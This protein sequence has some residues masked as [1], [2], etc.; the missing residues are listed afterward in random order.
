HVQRSVGAE[1]KA[2]FRLI[3]LERRHAQV[4]QDA[5]DPAQ[6]IPGQDGL[7]V[8]KIAVDQDDRVAVGRQGGA[9]GSQSARVPID[10]QQPPARQQEGQEGPGVSAPAHRAVHQHLPRRRLQDL[11][12]LVHHYR[13]VTHRSHLG[14]YS[15]KPSRF[16]AISPK[17][18]PAWATYPAQRSAAQISTRVDTPITTASFSSPAYCR[19]PGGSMMR[20]CRSGSHSHAPE[21]RKRT[22]A[23]ASA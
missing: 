7:E 11:D 23:R 21:N 10:A 3:Q 22:K 6:A 8:A 13:Y 18:S 17:D 9:G 14:L 20:P 2:P 1:G 5:V 19:R 12:H 16:S 15:P 4:E